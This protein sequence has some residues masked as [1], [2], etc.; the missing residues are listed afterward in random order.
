MGSVPG[1]QWRRKLENFEEDRDKKFGVKEGVT[2]SKTHRLWLIWLWSFYSLFRRPFLLYFNQYRS[3]EFPLPGPFR[4][5]SRKKS[6]LASAGV[7]SI[8]HSHFINIHFAI[9]HQ[10]ASLDLSVTCIAAALIN[11]HWLKIRPHATIV[12]IKIHPSPWTR[13]HATV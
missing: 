5:R 9:S 7:L 4:F 11:G 1:R 3:Q 6:L 8:Q 10:S 12:L 2:P 13:Y